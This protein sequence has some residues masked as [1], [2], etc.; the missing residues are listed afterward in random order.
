[1]IEKYKSYIPLTQ[2]LTRN[3]IFNVLGWVFPTIFAF[4]TI[5]IILN[6]I[7]TEKFGIMSLITIVSGYL[8]LLHSPISFGVVKYLADAFGKEDWLQFKLYL[9]SGF[10]ASIFFSTTGAIII[11]VSAQYMVLHV[12]VIPPYL[13]K[14]AIL[15]FQYAA[16][17]FFL[18]GIVAYLHGI[19]SAIRRYDVQ[20][21]GIVLTGV[22]SMFAI[23]VAMQMGYGLIEIIII[24]VIT[25][26]LSIIYFG[27][28]VITL[29]RRFLPNVKNIVIKMSVVKEI[30]SYSLII[31][32]NQIIGTISLQLD[33]TIIGILLGTTAITYYSIPSKITDNLSSLSI[34]LAMALYPLSAESVALGRLNQFKSLYLRMARITSF[35]IALPSLFIIIFAYDLLA[36]WVGEEMADRS[37]LVLVLMACTVILRTPSS[38]AFQVNNG[39]GKARF[40]LLASIFLFLIILLAVLVLAPLYGIIGAAIG[41]AAGGSI[42][43]II[44]ELYSQRFLGETKQM[45]CC[46]HYYKVLI[47]SLLTAIIFFLLEFR[48]ISG[49]T[50]AMNFFIYITL[51]FFLSYLFHFIKNEEVQQT[52]NFVKVHVNQINHKYGRS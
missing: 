17:S 11:L 36:L 3:T 48:I 19:T 6:S 21:I 14:D 18:S 28:V 22:I 4:I 24:Q 38:I 15:A 30:I 45:L 43:S 33:K 16:F 25:Y 46:D 37:W 31:F 52:I 10:P 27:T 39:L 2:G 41:V 40:N 1:M 8:G 49:V 51:Y 29:L 20:N 7:G 34:R 5:P 44:Y 42:V 9:Y 35:I 47:V 32:A 26:C 12:F 23:I 50:F 13:E